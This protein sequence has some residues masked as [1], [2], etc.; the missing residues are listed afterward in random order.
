MTKLDLGRVRRFFLVVLTGLTLSG[1]IT[2]IT[3]GMPGPAPKEDRLRAQLDLA[4]GYM[5][6]RDWSR[7]KVPLQ[8]ALEID[9]LSVETHVLSAVLFQTENEPILAEKHFDRALKIAPDDPQALNNYGSFLYAQERYNDAL[10]PLQKLADNTNYRARPQVYESLG[11]AF[12]QLE[13]MAEAE[14]A[15]GRALELNFR[16]ARANLELAGLLFERGDLKESNEHFF[17]YNRVGKP[18]ARSTCLGLRLAIAAKDENQESRY[19]LSLNN[20]FQDQ[21]EQCLKTL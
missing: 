7:A 11:L 10:V 5:E 15:F 18:T 2:E 20:L 13:K 17:L 21:A 12:M 3:G 1:C 4:R 6:K 14:S 8:K 9:N 16:L 19:R